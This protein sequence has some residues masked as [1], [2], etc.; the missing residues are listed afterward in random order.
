[1]A[2][3]LRKVAA[4]IPP[5]Q[6]REGKSMETGFDVALFRVCES[7]QFVGRTAEGC[8]QYIAT[9]QSDVT[10]WSEEGDNG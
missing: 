5:T 1:M 3:R 6:R 9:C 8:A 4:D 10:A 7:R 2:A